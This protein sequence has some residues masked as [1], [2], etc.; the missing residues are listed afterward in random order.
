MTSARVETTSKYSSA[1]MP[2]RP[3]FFK[4]PMPAMPETTV[5]K[6]IGAISILI[7]LMKPSPS[8][9]IVAPQPGFSQPSSTP[10]TMAA[11][12][13]TYRWRKIFMRGAAG[14]LV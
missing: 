10:S 14:G 13:C 8:G 5:V 3:I 12:T 9:R 7:N 11:S 1:L 4:S 6:M 2:T